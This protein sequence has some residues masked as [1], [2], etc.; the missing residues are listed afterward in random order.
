M[1]IGGDQAVGTDG[2][3]GF[4][5][6]GRQGTAVDEE[7][8]GDDVGGDVDG[9]GDGA[10]GVGGEELVGAVEFEEGAARGGAGEEFHEGGVVVAGGWAGGG[11]EACV[12]EGDVEVEAARVGWV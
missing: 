3:G 4:E 11:V 7:E 12:G 8:E 6:V 9:D 2:E 1:I 10:A 5:E